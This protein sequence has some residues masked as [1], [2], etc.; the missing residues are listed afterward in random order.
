[1]AH[2]YKITSNCQD[3]H[4][5]TPYWLAM[6]VPF[7]NRI[8]YNFDPSDPKSRDIDGI[9]VGA[10]I[11]LDKEIIGWGTSSS[12]GG[13]NSGLQMSVKY[14][15]VDF[16]KVL[17]PGDWVIFWAFDNFA[18]YT[19]V[20]QKVKNEERANEFKDGLK[21]VGRV[22]SVMKNLTVMPQ[23]GQKRYAYSI[24]SN[25]FTEFT[26]KIYHNPHIKI[27]KL[28]LNMSWSRFSEKSDVLK[29]YTE[30][31]DAIPV[32]L[33]IMLGTGPGLKFKGDSDVR[34]SP[35]DAFKIPQIIG[36]ILLNPQKAET[37]NLFYSDIIE[38]LV[39]TQTY[40]ATEGFGWTEEG[41]WVGFQ[42]ELSQLKGNVACNPLNF[43]NKSIWN[44]LSDYAAAPINELYTCLRVNEN[45]NIMPTLVCRQTPL[46]SNAFKLLNSQHGTTKTTAFIELP[47]WQIDDSMVLNATV[48]TSDA[49]RVNY[50]QYFGYTIG[51]QSVAA[52]RQFDLFKPII[53]TQ[54][55]NRSGLCPDIREVPILY[56]PG[57]A[58]SDYNG[59]HQSSKELGMY[60][61]GLMAD[62]KME[63]HLKFAGT[64]VCKGIQVPVCEGDNLVFDGGIYHIE[65]VAHAGSVTGN[66]Q[67]DFT[68]TL[69]LTNGISIQSEEGTGIDEENDTDLDIVRKNRNI[70]LNDDVLDPFEEVTL[71]IGTD[72]EFEEN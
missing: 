3:S 65:R 38:A 16:N 54:D 57:N 71:P 26:T 52:A 69:T 15:G 23:T 45:G 39:G 43:N 29:G 35:N 58:N 33:E 36:K 61:N 14:F 44:I 51:E 49:I 17:A 47:R 4:Q 60:L 37:S 46:C 10:P 34:T 48:G 2:V 28:P 22:T 42:P 63:G 68:T 72:W 11:L 56:I 50:L 55:I 53:D 41:S 13:P 40:G 18:D 67:K 32:L 31:S 59:K 20:K 12:K 19:V 21:F 7:A 1:M 70:Y 66:G 6:I 5:A 27:P 9:E 64:L 62:I 25:G 24:A 8:T 30:P